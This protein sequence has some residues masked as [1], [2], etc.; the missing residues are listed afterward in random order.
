[1]VSTSRVSMA[2]NSEVIELTHA[3]NA[4]LVSFMISLSVVSSQ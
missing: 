3:S 1:M 4:F 2:A